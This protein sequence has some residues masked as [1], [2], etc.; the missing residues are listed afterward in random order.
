[1]PTVFEV[2]VGRVGNSLKIT[3]PKPACDG[4]DLKVGDTLVITVMDEAIEVKK[5]TGSY[6]N[7]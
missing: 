2:K 7:T 5:K 1:M 4:F 6:S 3:L